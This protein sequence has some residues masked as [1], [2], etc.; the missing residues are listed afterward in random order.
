MS[1]TRCSIRGCVTMAPDNAAL[2]LPEALEDDVP[3]RHHHPAWATLRR[4]L[5]HKLFVT[6]FVVF[7][8]FVLVALLA[9][10]IAPV[11][12]DKLAMRYRF[13]PPSAGHW[14]GTDNLGRSLWSRVIWGAQLSLIIGVSVVAINA[15]LGTIIGAVAGYFR[16]LDNVLMRINDALMAFP[17]V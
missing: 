14:F 17:A 16:P 4:L 2:T 13:L 5:H 10:W 1:A 7:A 15:V 3:E 9:R 8:V 11:D 12:P 6:G